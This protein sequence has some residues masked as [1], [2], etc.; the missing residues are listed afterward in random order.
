MHAGNCPNSMD[1]NLQ[2]V[3]TQGQQNFGAL[4]VCDSRY[5]WRYFINADWTI[6]AARLAC[7]QLKLNY[8]SEHKY[9]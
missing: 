8:L 7:K 6:G 1:G 4:Q 3:H 9:N 5:G 2:L